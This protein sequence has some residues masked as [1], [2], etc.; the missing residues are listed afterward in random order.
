MGSACSTEAQGT[1]R[2]GGD[3]AAAWETAPAIDPGSG[4]VHRAAG[5]T[6]FPADA[7]GV[8]R[9]ARTGGAIAG[10]AEDALDRTGVWGAGGLSFDLALEPGAH[11]VT[12][13]VAEIGPG[14]HA[15][16]ARVFDVALEGRVAEDDLDVNA[17][18]G[19]RAAL[20]LTH[21][22]ELE[23]GAL[24]LDRIPGVGNPILTGIEVAR[25]GGVA[26]DDAVAF[27]RDRDV[28]VDE[29]TG[30]ASVQLTA[31]NFLADDDAGE[32]A[33]VALVEGPADA[34]LGPAREEGVPTLPFDPARFDAWASSTCSALGDGG[35]ATARLTL[36]GVP[37]V[38]NVV[39]F[40]LFGG[41]SGEVR[42]GL[43]LGD[44]D[45][46]VLEAELSA[47]PRAGVDR[48]R[49]AAP[50]PWAGGGA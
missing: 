19:P 28:W 11:A 31:W 10:T 23:D 4:R 15:D 9:V 41:R 8:G 12:L 18:A 43:A 24:E 32:F 33:P 49:S 21:L 27:D 7:T 35:A 30:V 29:R 14:A 25:L 37:G 6:A 42:G 46:A 47:A 50:E 20:A 39:P 2:A 48:G 40:A 13:H 38:E 17:A 3:A 36:D 5:G 44:G 26:A 34:V 45:R 16:G 22:I 1:T